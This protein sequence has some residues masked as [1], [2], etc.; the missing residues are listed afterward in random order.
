MVLF[1]VAVLGA[2]GVAAAPVAAA[3]ASV[4]ATASV[5]S[6]AASSATPSFTV[7]VS[8]TSARPGE[9]VALTFAANDKD[10]TITTC[11]ATLDGQPLPACSGQ[12]APKRTVEFVVPQDTVPGTR[13]IPW[14]LTYSVQTVSDPPVLLR[15]QRSLVLDPYYSTG[16]V[17][18]T[19]LS[20]PP[21]VSVALDRDSGLTGDK[22]TATFTPDPSSRTRLT[23]CTV[24]IDGY[25][26]ADCTQEQG[27]WTVSFAVPEKVAPGDTT[28]GWSLEYLRG[29]EK[30]TLSGE[31]PFRVLP[32]EVQASI[33]ATLT[34]TTAAAGERVRA[35]FTASPDTVHITGC[36]ARLDGKTLP[37]CRQDASGWRIDFPVPRGIDPGP[38]VVLWR[39]TYAHDTRPRV[40]TRVVPPARE[41]VATGSLTLDVR[42]ATPVTTGPTTTADPTPPPDPTFLARLSTPTASAGDVLTMTVVPSDPGVALS[43][44]AASILGHTSSGCPGSRGTWSAQVTVPPGTGAGPAVVHWTLS[45]SRPAGSGAGAAVGNASG[46]LTLDIVAQGI[47]LVDGPD[48]HPEAAV[49]AI[50]LVLLAVAP[51]VQEAL[52]RHRKRTNRTE[53]EAAAAPATAAVHVVVSPAEPRA[54]VERDPDAEPTPGLQFHTHLP[55][56]S[57]ELEDVR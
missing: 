8:P 11:G 33:S 27:P 9:P 28:V 42:P 30:G 53:A 25:T 44:C 20:P 41:H 13:T 16:E 10:V 24:A 32:P 3:S 18:F 31:L 34:P 51:I 15:A 4:S 17:D 26:F 56:A 6:S 54:W 48:N 50:L 7:S 49:L 52:R 43:G 29:K 22:V 14:R 55:P 45:W 12:A 38:R 37:T 5:A 36:S 1:G 2:P 35:R 19:V 46:D 47:T 40:F 57:V 23:T 39:V 21:Q